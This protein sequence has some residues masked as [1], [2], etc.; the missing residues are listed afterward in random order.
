MLLFLTGCAGSEGEAQQ[1]A[2]AA[3]TLLAAGD[4][5]GAR[6]AIGRAIAAD[7]DDPSI[8]LLDAQIKYRMAEYRA[9]FEA[10]QTLLVF[11]PDNIEALSA[12]AQLGIGLSD[13][14][15]SRRAIERALQID[16][17][18]VDV[19]MSR[20][21]LE[22]NDNEYAEAERTAQ[23]LSQ[24][25]GGQAR[26][27]IVRARI[28]MKQNRPEAAYAL[29]NQTVSEVGNDRLLA[30]A[31]LEVARREREVPVMLEQYA[32]L[33]P[34]NPASTALPLDEINVRY[35]TGDV[36]GARAKTGEYIDRFGNDNVAMRQLAELWTEY[37]DQPLN[38]GTIRDLAGSSKAA[39]R[40]A[41]ARFYLAEG[42][43]EQA[44]RMVET[45]PDGRF[46]GVISRLHVARGSKVGADL[47]RQILQSD[48]TDCDALTAMIEWE[49]AAR[50]YSPAI[51]Q[52]QTLATQCSDRIDG[53]LHLADAYKA[54]GNATSVER[55]YRDGI[56]VHPQNARLAES[57]ANW[58]I[59]QGRES[60]A[61]SVVRRLGNA[62]PTR[63][64][65]WRVYQN[66]CRQAGNS[67]C[68]RTAADGLAKA[69]RTLVFDP[70][71]GLKP[72]DPLLGHSWY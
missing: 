26:G 56:E 60:S 30:T 20:A 34:L 1:E 42:E 57:F 7:S 59:E 27:T 10:Y 22:L 52:A 40:L 14:S 44:D 35:K 70:L 39:A 16:P 38:D 51:V 5:P 48:T 65:T 2:S 47:A 11:E 68:S 24:I 54:S 63:P 31:L 23:K 37:D 36:D 21:V 55:A 29:L 69:Q 46:M 25:S 32:Y 41:A 72:A 43:I 50:R 33:I 61:V 15:A 62:A 18:N 66:V 64:S 9:A 19:L 13:P 45:S 58:L 12:V 8:L 4:L 67:A 17:E 49:M 53:Y 6:Q 28:L 3:R 71:P